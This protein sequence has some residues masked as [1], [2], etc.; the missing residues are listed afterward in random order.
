MSIVTRH[1]KILTLG[2]LLLAVI[3]VG[4]VGYV[5]LAGGSFIDALYM[6]IITVTT[7]GFKEAFPLTPVGKVFTIVLIV[8]GL[9]LVFYFLNT[10]IEDTMEGRIRKILGRRKMEKN[11]ARMRNH[12]IIVGFGR[13][14][15][16]VCKELEAAG[17]EFLIV[18]SS[19]Q[20][21]AVA[22]EHNY[23]VLNASA[24]DEEALKAAGIEKAR[25]F[26]ALLPD[27]VD[28][29]FTILSARE[30][31][32][33]LVIITRALDA[34]NE[35]KLY[36]AGATRVVSPYDLTSHRIVRMVQTPNVVD[37]FDFLLSSHKYTLSLEE[38]VIGEKSDLV[39]KTIRDAGLRER[40]NAI[41]VAVRRDGE[42]TFN[43]GPDLTLQSG[44]ILILI[45]ERE[46]LHLVG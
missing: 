29:L 8:T 28:N 40:F 34:A 18:E 27:D 24:T 2:A 35:K 10:I 30:L 26:V 43:P 21:F 3:A 17:V 4:T 44:D 37:F 36:K 15:E 41:I 7:V 9:G 45:G 20:R 1:R 6:T 39:G 5:F 38:K 13:M 31:N 33:S 12:V 19:P 42:M 11:M 14:A 23:N 46:A 22:E 16:V 25:V 32:P